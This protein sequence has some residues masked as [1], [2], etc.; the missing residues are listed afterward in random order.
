MTRIESTVHVTE[1][2]HAMPN[3]HTAARIAEVRAII[4]RSMQTARA[5]LAD[6][7]ES[8]AFLDRLPA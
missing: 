5:A 4:D 7:P 3:Y 2:S 8:L 1:R 6:N